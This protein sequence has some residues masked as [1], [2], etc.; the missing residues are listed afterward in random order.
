VSAP[1]LALEVA[2]LNAFHGSSH[3]LQGVDIA[4]RPGEVVALLG[5]NGAGKTTT[6]RALM[7]LLPPRAGLVRLFGEPLARLPPFAIA[8]RGMAMVLEDRGMFPSLTVREC[9]GLAG[10]SVGRRARIE[11]AVAQFPRL[12]ERLD[13]G[14]ATLRPRVLLLDEP[15]QGLAPIVVRE[16]LDRLLLL[17]QAGL[18]ILLVEQALA[19]ATRLADIALVLGKGTVQWSGPA[20]A[21]RADQ[22]V[23]SEWLGV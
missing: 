8:R 4:V 16:L 22:G 19:F 23:I 5:R 17:K 11:E 14:C 1:T 13:H 6:L 18:S 7:N 2:G 15:T 3:V 12:G 10:P 9:L 21:L 20:Q